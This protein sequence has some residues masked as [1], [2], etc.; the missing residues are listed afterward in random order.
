MPH[1]EVCDV[2]LVYDTPAGRVEGVAAASFAIEASEFLCLVGPSGCGKSTL[3]NIV[4]GFLAPTGGE[5]RIDGKIVTGQ[6]LDR[7]V[8]F[9]DFALLPHLTVIENVAFP[10]RVRGMGR[11][12]REARAAE[13]VSLVGLEER[14]DY[15]PHELSGG[16]QQ[17][18]GIARSLASDPELWFLDEP[19]S[20]LD[21][22]IRQDL[23]GELLR[24]LA[25]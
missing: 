6:G 16:Q 25:G 15:Y 3:L 20:A 2:S 18:V 22:L 19:F 10:L 4:A 1:I 21:P 8:V 12:E 24:R 17:R 14:E 23:Q 5:V 13:M 11:A 7:G 9:Q